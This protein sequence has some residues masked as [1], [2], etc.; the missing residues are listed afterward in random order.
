[1]VGC[2][3][4]PPPLPPPVP[5]LLAPAGTPVTHYG[6][7]VELG[8]PRPLRTALA[9]EA[10]RLA[11]QGKRP[12]PELDGPL[13]AVAQA[14]AHAGRGETPDAG[15]VDFAAGHYGVAV[16]IPSVLVM[17]GR[18][19]TGDFVRQISPVLEQVLRRGRYNRLGVGVA[20]VEG[21][22]VVVLLLQEDAV[23]LEP[24]PRHL[25]VGGSAPIRGR[26]Q[27]HREAQVLATGADGRV[28][29][30]QQGSDRF[31]AS[32]QCAAEG[33]HRVEVMG[34]HRGGPVVLANF[35]IYCGAPPPT[36]LAITLGV[37][38]NL[39]AQEAE[40]V[41]LTA[42]NRER[43]Q[44]DLPPLK[45]DERLAEVARGHSED[46]RTHGFVG[47]IS[48]TTGSPGD[49]VKAARLVAGTVEENVGVGPSPETVHTGL[50]ESPAHRAAILSATATAIGI[51]VVRRQRQGMADYFT[52]QVLTGPPAPV[53]AAAARAAI[54]AK[55]SGRQPDAG[56][57]AVAQS[58]AQDL[59]TGRLDPDDTQAATKKRLKNQKVVLETL[60]ALAGV[61]PT[62]A[63]LLKDPVFARSDLP[64]F[65]VGVA[66]GEQ[67]G[68]PTLFTVVLLG[69]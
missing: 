58:L 65:G 28:Q 68:Y 32:F 37:G 46:M 55:L 66:A 22:E 1:M 45:W 61:G 17:K 30:L 24:V 40:Q 7:A 21:D 56:L 4:R 48:P 39:D 42:V 60:A 50:M 54:E 35:S 47:H 49:R 69:R 62:P 18:G 12:R 20:A 26:I 44:Q 29:V 38:S 52:T 67:G 34:T 16:P 57:Q 6:A 9:T 5:G 10:V 27:G 64:R 13:S 63:T 19:S 31:D 25:P 53:D 3:S 51:G 15:A 11:D 33:R 43:K 41:L 2:A 36:K 14:L 23:A 59:A 8:E